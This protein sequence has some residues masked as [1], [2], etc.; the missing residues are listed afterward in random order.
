MSTRQFPAILSHQ[1]TVLLLSNL[2]K[3]KFEHRFGAERAWWYLS[4]ILMMHDIRQ[5]LQVSRIEV[6]ID[7]TLSTHILSVNSRLWSKLYRFAGR[8]QFHFSLGLNPNLMF[9]RREVLPLHQPALTERDNNSI[10]IS[11]CTKRSYT[12]RRTSRSTRWSPTWRASSRITTLSY[13][14]PLTDQCEFNV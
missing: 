11:R 12:S 4:Q 13:H 10:F 3:A 1:F 2:L 8:W 6:R 14:S 9:E 7:L 5:G